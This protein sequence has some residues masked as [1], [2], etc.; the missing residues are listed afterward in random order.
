MCIQFFV[1]WFYHYYYYNS[2]VLQICS[3]C[4]TVECDVSFWLCLSGLSDLNRTF[5]QLPIFKAPSVH[6]WKTQVPI[7]GFQL[8]WRGAEIVIYLYC[9]HHLNPLSAHVVLEAHL[10]QLADRSLRAGE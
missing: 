4:I 9:A 2:V 10:P 1:L 6:R 7:Q 3:V 5:L 8:C